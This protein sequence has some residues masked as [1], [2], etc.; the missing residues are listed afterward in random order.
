MALTIALTYDPILPDGMEMKSIES[1]T[2][3][4][5]GKGAQYNKNVTTTDGTFSLASITTLGYVKIRN[6]AQQI[7]VIPPAA[8]TVSPQ[9][10]TGTTSWSYL[11]VATQSDGTYSSAGAVGN[12]LLGNAVLNAT[13]FNQLQWPLITG[14]DSYDIYRTVAAGTP[15]T[16]GKIAS[17]TLTLFNDTGLVGDGTTAPSVAADNL[18]L[19]S[20]DGVVYPLSLRGQEIFM[21][22]WN[23]AAI[24]HKASTRTV[25]VEI[26]L[27][28][29]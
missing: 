18:I 4:L 8:P 1:I 7:L 9:G 16:L 2:I 12:T 15:S 26:V 21:G 13:N 23:A 24:H 22:R 25:P 28:D 27:L 3:P 20:D 10:T 5:T 11:V 17:T 6:R 14:A 29:A 19:L